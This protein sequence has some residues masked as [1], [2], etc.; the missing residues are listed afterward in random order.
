[1]SD[2]DDTFI[3]MPS[4]FMRLVR[5]GAV[6]I[7]Y[8]V[9]KPV[10]GPLNSEQLLNMARMGTS[11]NFYYGIEGGVMAFTKPIG[12][13]EFTVK[14]VSRNY[15]VDEAGSSTKNEFTK[16]TDTM[17][18]PERLLV[19]GIIWRFRRDAKLKYDDQLKEWEADLAL[20]INQDRGRTA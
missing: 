7:T 5:G 16:D 12:T 4:D 8:P 15:A 3:D 2:Q 20:E 9:K 18:F 6:T 19:K 10:R 14:Y 17:T 11:L 13:N 1:M